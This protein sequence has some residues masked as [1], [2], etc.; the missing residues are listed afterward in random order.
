VRAFSRSDYAKLIEKTD[1]KLVRVNTIKLMLDGVMETK[2]GKPKSYRR[3]CLRTHQPLRMPFVLFVL[4]D[5]SL[6][7]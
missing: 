6:P 1:N 7:S 4:F 2:T 5:F 3:F